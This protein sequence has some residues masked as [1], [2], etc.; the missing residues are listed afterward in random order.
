MEYVSYEFVW[1]VGACELFK[2]CPKKETHA[3][4]HD[5]SL[6]VDLGETLDQKDP[7]LPNLLP[8]PSTSLQ[9]HHKSLPEQKHGNSPRKFLPGNMN[10]R[11]L[12]ITLQ[13]KR[14]VLCILI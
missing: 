1:E 4:I 5:H 10:A 6:P 7:Q 8:S 3:S 11:K 14:L 2:Y 13:A 9:I 12:I